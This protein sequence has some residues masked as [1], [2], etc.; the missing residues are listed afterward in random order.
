MPVHESGYGTKRTYRGKRAHVRFWS[1]ADIQGRRV[2]IASVADDIVE[3]KRAYGL[4]VE[5][6]SD[7]RESSYSFIDRIIWAVL[8]IAI[9]GIGGLIVSNL[10]LLLGS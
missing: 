7:M 3:L 5:P 1:E 2:S 4:G 10:Q 6:L 9:I 8:V